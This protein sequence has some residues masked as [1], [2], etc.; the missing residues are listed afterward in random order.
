MWKNERAVKAGLKFRPY[1]ETVKDTLAWYKT[2]HEGQRTKLA[3]P[4]PQKEAELLEAW[5][6]TQA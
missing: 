5:K 3:G 1:S 2:Q 4:T 6:R